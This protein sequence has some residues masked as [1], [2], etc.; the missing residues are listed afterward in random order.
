[1][2]RQVLSPPPCVN[3][4]AVGVLKEG[5]QKMGTHA[6][7][8][9]SKDGSRARCRLIGGTCDAAACLSLPAHRWHL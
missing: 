1:M 9:T 4:S 3:L 6:A 7:A 2:S 8:H 5:S